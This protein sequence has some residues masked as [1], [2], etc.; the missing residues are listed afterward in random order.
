MNKQHKRRQS[1]QSVGARPATSFT[2]VEVRPRHDGWTPARQVAVVQA[3]AACGCVEEACAAVGM[4]PRS[5]YDLRARP[6]ADSF[7]QAV[8][9]ALDVGVQRLS[10]AVIGRAIHG[11]V[12]PIFYKGEQIGEKRRFDNQLA[13]FVLRIRAPERY[14][15]WREAAQQHRDH[16]DGAAQMLK[17]AVRHLAEDAAA[18]AVGRP[19]PARPLLKTMRLMDD[20]REIAE[21]ERLDEESDRVR[22]AADQA[23][24]DAEWE[25]YLQNH[26]TPPSVR[27]PDDDPAA[28]GSRGS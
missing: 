11:E 24:R 2:P 18:D 7:R 13:M 17:Q 16:P 26:N 12:T 25:S 20:P 21:Q 19:R 5:F 1:R 8:E 22:E 14:G 27:A 3:L 28:D 10:D 4:S 23:R 9:L 15:K 6:G